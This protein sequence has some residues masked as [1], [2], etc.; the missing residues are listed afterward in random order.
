MADTD[1][2][3]WCQEVNE[4]VVL[5]LTELRKRVGKQFL[6]TSIQLDICF[7]GEFNL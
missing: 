3:L 5:M 1:K 2:V 6:R 7:G 4:I